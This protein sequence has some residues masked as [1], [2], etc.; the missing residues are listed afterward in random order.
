M[1]PE[2]TQF[3]KSGTREFIL[4]IVH[5]FININYVHEHNGV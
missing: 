4:F 3:P 5:T 2:T 1:V